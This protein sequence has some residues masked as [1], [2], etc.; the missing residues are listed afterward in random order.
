V[1]VRRYLDVLRLI[2]RD[3]HGYL[4]AVGLRARWARQG[5]RVMPGAVIKARGRVEI[6]RGAIIGGDSVIVAGEPEAVVEIGA[7]TKVNRRCFIT[8]KR[9]IAIGRHVLFSNNVF[10]CDHLHAFDDLGTPVMR[11]GATEARPVEIGEGTWLGINVVVM[12]GVR[13]GRHCV[14]GA[15]SVVTHDVPDFGVAVGAPAR[16][17]RSLA[18]A[19]AGGG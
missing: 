19:G 13:V 9:R 3:V 6:E 5:V 2:G 14:I 4:H 11:Q 8:A 12:P 1:R 16:L 15:N 17:V 10:I 7:G 18:P